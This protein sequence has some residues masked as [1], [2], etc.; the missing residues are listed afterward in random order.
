MKEIKSPGVYIFTCIFT[1]GARKF[2]EKFV[3]LRV[4]TATKMI[5]ISELTTIWISFIVKSYIL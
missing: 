4:L 2:K 5:L 3:D 1:S